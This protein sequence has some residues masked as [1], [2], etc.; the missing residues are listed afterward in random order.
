LP[1]RHRFSIRSGAL[2][3]CMSEFQLGSTC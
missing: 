2:H 1:T 3:R